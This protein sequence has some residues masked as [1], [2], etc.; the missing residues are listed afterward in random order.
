MPRERLKLALDTDVALALGFER[1]RLHLFREVARDQG[2]GFVLT[3]TVLAQLHIL[4]TGSDTELADAATCV[5]RERRVWDIQ[6]VVFDSPAE[7]KRIEAIARHLRQKAWLP[8]S[9]YRD[10]LVVAECSVACIPMLVVFD[11]DY[12]PAKFN[13][14]LFASL[15]SI[16]A[17]PVTVWKPEE[18]LDY[19]A[20]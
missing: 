5:L 10:A 15:V 17:A 7:N 6:A 18:L 2:C 11:T 4:L 19:W 1:E 3:P 13:P 8:W 12:P 14:H 16:N 9:E 20:R